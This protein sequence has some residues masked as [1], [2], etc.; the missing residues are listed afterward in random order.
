MRM[1]R[2]MAGGRPTMAAETFLPGIRD[3]SASE[4][5]SITR[6]NGTVNRPLGSELKRCSL[7]TDSTHT[8]RNAFI[9]PSV[10]Q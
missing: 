3:A 5:M 7:E 6:F 4:R 1:S 2:G 8:R 9:R 10:T